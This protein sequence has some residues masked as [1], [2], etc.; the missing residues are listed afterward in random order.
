MKGNDNVR[1]VWVRPVAQGA[2]APGVEGRNSANLAKASAAVGDDET[3][4]QIDDVA[5]LI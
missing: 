4:L 5:D 2:M 1:G 3:D